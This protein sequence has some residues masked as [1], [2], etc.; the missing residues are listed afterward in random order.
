MNKKFLVPSLGSL[1]MRSGFCVIN[2]TFA[3]LQAANSAALEQGAIKLRV[4]AVRS[5]AE[6]KVADLLFNP[7]QS[8]LWSFDD[9]WGLLHEPPNVGDDLYVVE[10][11]AASPSARAQA[12]MA[13]DLEG[14]LFFAAPDQK[15][16]A[17]V[18]NGFIPERSKGY[19]FAPIFHAGHYFVMDERFMTYIC[20]VNYNAEQMGQGDDGNVMQFKL[21]TDAGDVLGSTKRQI[22]FNSTFLISVG[23]LLEEIGVDKTSTGHVSIHVRGGAS[24][25]AIYTVHRNLATG[26]IGIEHSLAPHYYTEAVMKPE[27]RAVLYQKVFGGL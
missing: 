2:P 9:E 23:D 17:T 10:Y 5:G 1:G 14:Q 15:W 24:Q 13:S 21:L 18:I 25:Y 6:L 12:F 22:R 3:K 19:R 4:Q 20:L 16:Y 26:T 7:E 11:V 27:T 8:F